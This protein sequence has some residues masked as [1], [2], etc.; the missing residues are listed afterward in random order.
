MK[1][2]L[3]TLA[4]ASVLSLS[5]FAS[6][7][8]GASADHTDPHPDRRNDRIEQRLDWQSDRAVA[9]GHDPVA[10]RLDHLGDP[11]DRRLHTRGGRIDRGLERRGARINRRVDR[12]SRQV[13]RRRAA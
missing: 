11:I 4:A 6:A 5:S 8:H 2:Y 3:I 9:A 12:Q 13:N 7:E 1:T 10:G